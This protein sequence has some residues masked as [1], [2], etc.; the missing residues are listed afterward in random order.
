[1]TVECACACCVYFVRMSTK[2]GWKKR[3][4]H[5]GG[6]AQ[7]GDV[8][9]Y[10]ETEGQATEARGPDPLLGAVLDAF[11]QLLASQ[12]EARVMLDKEPREHFK[13]LGRRGT[14]R[15]MN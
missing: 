15:H 7:E 14:M 2:D 1:M 4:P 12:E 13:R 9:Y 10:G 11:S 5:E 8:H 3:P 6:G